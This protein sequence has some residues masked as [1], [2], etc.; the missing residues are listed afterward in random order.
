MEHTKNSA[1]HLKLKGLCLSRSGEK[2]LSNVSLNLPSPGVSV[3]IGANGAGKSTLLKV[4]AGINSP[5]S[6]ELS[7]C[8]MSRFYMPEPAVFYPRLSVLEQL[9][10]V[11]GL[12]E[13]SADKVSEAVS[14]WQ[15][16]NQQ[17]KLTKHL[18]LGYKQRLALA[19]LSLSD[20]NIFLMD[21]PM[22]GMDPDVLDVFK[23]QVANWK[24]SKT[25]I[26]ATHVM[27]EVAY[28]VDWVVV[29]HQGKVVSTEP[30]QSGQSLS[31][32]YHQSLKSIDTSRVTDYAN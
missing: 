1:K 31:Q 8:S 25:L 32:I 6:G 27:Q 26:I 3:L 15:L 21:E 19:Q 30:F 18:S 17:H 9:E 11:A 14:T 16:K 10:F 13:A 28:L 5:D 12:F 23:Q 4:L 22:N 7:M 20:T 29:M 2:I 24:Q